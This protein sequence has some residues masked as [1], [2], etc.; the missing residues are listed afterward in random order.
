MYRNIC[1]I[2]YSVLFFILLSN[3]SFSY[4]KQWEKIEYDADNYLIFEDVGRVVKNETSVYY[5]DYIRLHL[6]IDGKPSKLELREIMFP[7]R[8]HPI[9]SMVRIILYSDKTRIW[10]I[11]RLGRRLDGAVLLDLMTGEIKKE[12]YGKN[13][14]FSKDRESIAFRYPMGSMNS[15]NAIFVDDMMVYPKIESGFTVTTFEGPRKTDGTRY[16]TV[17]DP[18]QMPD[19]CILRTPIIWWENSKIEFV[20]REVHSREADLTDPSVGEF[21]DYM[22]EGLDKRDDPEVPINII[23]TVLSPDDAK[24]IIASIKDVFNASSQ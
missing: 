20:L 24:Q 3:A 12:H 21:I 18:S 15:K 19:L 7:V 13:F 14:C 5:G 10:M 2:K 9:S 17:I 11:S 16:G 23:K 4:L 6:V 1:L 22:I 8:K